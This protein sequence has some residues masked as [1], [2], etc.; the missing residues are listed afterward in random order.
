MYTWVYFKNF[1][2]L[3]SCLA[4]HTYAIEEQK[5]GTMLVK[6]GDDVTLP[7]QIDTPVN[8]DKATVEWTRLDLMPQYVYLL[9]DGLVV[10]DYLNPL[11]KYRTS[12]SADKMSH[13]N[14][15]MK[16]SSVRLSDQGTY[17]CNVPNLSSGAKIQLRVGKVSKPVIFSIDGG[18]HV[19]CDSGCWYPAPMMSLGYNEGQFYPGKYSQ[20]ERD[21]ETE[22]C[23]V[24]QWTLNVIQAGTVLCRVHLR[25]IN[26]T[27]ERHT[28]VPEP[29]SRAKVKANTSSQF[30]N[31]R[32]TLEAHTFITEDDIKKKEKATM[33]DRVPHRNYTFEPHT[34]VPQENGY[35]TGHPPEVNYTLEPWTVIPSGGTMTFL[36][37]RLFAF[38]AITVMLLA[39]L[40]GFLKWLKRQNNGQ[41]HSEIIYHE[42]LL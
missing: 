40:L 6:E 29:G 19:V 33:T 14:L 38:I 2:V 22:H 26:Y 24:I 34:L 39:L 16:M 23:Y 17:K 7:C 3:W 8:P 28:A 35:V 11:Y 42:T 15:S 31:V 41:M 25:H 32:S 30:V 1:L 13:G 21:P 37:L 36:V 18:K 10:T 4:A 9:Q 5:I 12:V 27:L 20:T